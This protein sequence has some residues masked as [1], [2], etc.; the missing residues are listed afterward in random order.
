MSGPKKD[1]LI[2]E[3]R[4]LHEEERNSLYYLHNCREWL[5]CCL[6]AL[7]QFESS[8]KLIFFCFLC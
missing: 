1:G 5:V 8:R 4:K 7:F 3:T 2:R 6:M